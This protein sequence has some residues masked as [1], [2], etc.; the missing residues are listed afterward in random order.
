MAS[1]CTSEYPITLPVPPSG[2]C[3]MPA[4]ETLQ[5]A[6]KDRGTACAVQYINFPVDIPENVRPLLV[7]YERAVRDYRSWAALRSWNTTYASESI[8][9]DDSVES[10]AKRVGYCA[11][12][13]DYDMRNTP[14]LPMTKS[15]TKEKTFKVETRSFHAA[16][17]DAVTD[18]FVNVPTAAYGT[19]EKVFHVINTAIMTQ[20]RITENIQ[21]LIILQR[22]EYS[23]STRTIRHSYCLV[24]ITQEMADVQRQKGASTHLDVAISYNE[25]EAQ[26]DMNEWE[27]VSDVID[28]WKKKQMTEY[29]EKDTT[30]VAV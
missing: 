27:R 24:E 18:G 10:A 16:L 26:F 8:P 11:R 29:V 15:K 22:Y 12:V 2:I 23:P 14:W 6:E 3:P 19:L 7:Q 17:V 21:Q 4:D 1:I 30:E 28:E 9:Q 13:T 25:Y 5:K 20:Y